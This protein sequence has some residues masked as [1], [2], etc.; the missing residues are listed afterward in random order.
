[1][2]E[3]KAK[4]Q[5]SKF[6]F[7]CR[8]NEID[9]VTAMLPKLSLTEINRI[10]PNGS[11]ALHAAAYY[12]NK[13]IVQLLLSKGA[14]HMI[15]NCHNSTPLGEAKTDDIK[16]LFVR[17]DDSETQS[18]G[19]FTSEKS[20]SYEWIFLKADPS[21]YASFN[22]HSLLKCEND[23]QFDRLCRGI[24]QYYINEDGP[25]ANENKIEVI[26]D[27]FDEAI[28]HNDP[29]KVVRAY[30]AHTGFF[31]RLNCDLSQLPTHWSGSKHERNIASIMIFHPKC[32]KYSFTGET[33]RGMTMSKT[34]LNEYTVD[35]VFMNKT[36]LS[37]SK[38]RK[39][40]ECFAE[41]ITSST[42]FSVVCKYVIKHSGTALAIETLSEY[43]DEKEVLILPYAV[44][45]VK[46]IGKSMGKI[47][48]IIEIE[49]EEEEEQTK[50]TLKKSYKTSHSSVKTSKGGQHC[51]DAYKKM[52]KDSQEKGKIDPADLAKWKK[53]SFGI[54]PETD[55]YAKMWND[56][57]HGKFSKSD[58]LKWKKENGFNSKDDEAQDSDLES[59]DGENDPTIFTASNEQSYA[60]SKKISSSQPFH[61]KKFMS[62]FSD[63]SDD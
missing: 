35:T 62:E 11:T 15:K 63:D 39:Q 51:N 59:Y 46:S 26:R 7:A 52:F 40:A 50:W 33:F 4:P 1:M 28:E 19:R 55:T 29:T 30:T 57:K 34:D 47:G 24:R 3:T 12:G 10:E 2:S 13:E 9:T 36:F 5:P 22:R 41:P 20:V 44:F 31:K 54:D 49:V 48:E 17:P 32:Q 60:T 53:E 45:K 38:K 27:F 25:L 43:P 16:K 58:L 42:V 21:S 61:M 8:N 56:G 37:T 6:Y 14:Q 23:E 18:G